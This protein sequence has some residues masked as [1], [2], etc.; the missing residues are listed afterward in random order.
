MNLQNDLT[1]NL[2]LETL[3]FENNILNQNDNKINFILKTMNLTEM[4]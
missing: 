3:L 2:T 4:M 1:T